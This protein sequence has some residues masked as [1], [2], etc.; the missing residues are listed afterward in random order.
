[1]HAVLLRSIDISCLPGQQQQIRRGSRY[2]GQTHGR[3]PYR[4]IDAAAYDVNR[5]APMKLTAAAVSS[6]GEVENKT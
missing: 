6:V 5:T 1:M 2:M 3:T 4:Y